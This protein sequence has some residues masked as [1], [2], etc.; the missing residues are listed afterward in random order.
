MEVVAEI[1]LITPMDRWNMDI[2]NIIKKRLANVEFM[3]AEQ[4][5]DLLDALLFQ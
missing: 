5:L 3:T 2:V 1:S 4:N